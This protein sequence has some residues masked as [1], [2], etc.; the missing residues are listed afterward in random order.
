MEH[1]PIP[2]GLP[3]LYCVECGYKLCFV[4]VCF[5]EI[6]TELPLPLQN[7]AYY[8]AESELNQACL[9]KW[10]KFQNRSQVWTET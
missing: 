1:M 6:R 2:V 4:S 10:A 8:L 5:T 3:K 7:L 9:W